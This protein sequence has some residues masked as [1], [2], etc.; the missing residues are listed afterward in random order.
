MDG[1][2]NHSKVNFVRACMAPSDLEMSIFAKDG[3]IGAT[4]YHDS[5]N[6]NLR[7]GT[8]IEDSGYW[9]LDGPSS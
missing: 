1:I 4:V 6:R 2:S 9:I 7:T 8:S 5:V 3:E